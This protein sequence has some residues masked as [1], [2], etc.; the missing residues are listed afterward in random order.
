MSKSTD[1]INVQL[2]INFEEQTIIKSAQFNVNLGKI[3]DPV[4]EIIDNGL[5]PAKIRFNGDSGDELSIFESTSFSLGYRGK[6][7]MLKSIEWE[8]GL[9]C[10]DGVVVN[11]FLCTENIQSKMELYYS[12]YLEELSTVQSKLINEH[13]IVV[14]DASLPHIKGIAIEWSSLFD[15]ESGLD[16]AYPLLCDLSEDALCY[17]NLEVDNDTLKVFPYK[18]FYFKKYSELLF[19]NEKLIR[20]FEN[21]QQVITFKIGSLIATISKPSLLFRLINAHFKRNEGIMS[22][23][24][25]Y[26][27]KFHDIDKN[28]LESSLQQAIFHFNNQFNPFRKERT[29][30][31]IPTNPQIRSDIGYLSSKLND[32]NFPKASHIS[33]IAFFNEASNSTGYEAF[34]NYYKVLEYFFKTGKEE[35]IKM[36][37]EKYKSDDELA[38]F[39]QEIVEVAD[40]KE[41]NALKNLVLVH[42]NDILITVKRAKAF[43]LITDVSIEEFAESLYE[44]RNM[45]VHAKEDNSQLRPPKLLTTYGD[46]EWLN[47]TREFAK[48][49][50]DLHCFRTH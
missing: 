50:I 13:K 4:I 26:T 1:I 2:H 38:F 19:M 35:K 37:A 39:V 8:V 44:F 18:G 41:I 10:E 24:D 42:Q 48:K 45:Y 16:P 32:K 22:W 17:Y 25:F 43:K 33:A 40:R 14:H 21:N 9:D 7:H 11:I 49:L 12:V 31:R 34:I 36:L 20:L 6:K 15:F 28:E 29:T 3:I 5:E 30:F 23:D 47:I 27:I 46:E